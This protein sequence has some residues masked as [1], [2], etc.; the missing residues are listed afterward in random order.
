[1]QE[2]K[3]VIR[4]YKRLDKQA[5][6]KLLHTL[7]T[8][9]VSLIVLE[10]QSPHPK[11]GV[12][13][14]SKISHLYGVLEGILLGFP[15]RVIEVRPP[16]WKK[17]LKLISNTNKNATYYERKVRAW[18]LASRLF[19]EYLPLLLPKT[20]CFDKAESLLLAYWGVQFYIEKA[21]VA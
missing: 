10:L 3:K 15:T 12:A 9:A 1:M 4:I 5:L 17:D 8:P 13:S 21:R 7:I 19:S 11:Q 18:T 14:G 2:R 6:W 16:R 20:S